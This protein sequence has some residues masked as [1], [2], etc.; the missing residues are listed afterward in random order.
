MRLAKRTAGSDWKNRAQFFAIAANLMRQILVDHARNRR[1]LCRGGEDRPIPFEEW[2]A[3]K[4]QRTEDILALHEA[5]ERL[6]KLDQRQSRIVELRFFSG[7]SEAEIAD[8]MDISTRTVKRDWN[9]AKAWL[10]SEMSK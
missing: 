6:A 8:V 5:L 7:L 10:Y 1:A 2:F 9:F 4:E 3:A